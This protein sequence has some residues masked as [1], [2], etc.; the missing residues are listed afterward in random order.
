MIVYLIRHTTPNIERG[1]CYGQ[2]DIDVSDIF[3]EEANFLLGKIKSV[4]ITDVISSP[5]QRCTK[6]ATKIST[7]YT[8][9]AS[10][11]ELDFGNWE[12]KKWNA[13]PDEETNPWMNDFV[14]VP[15]PNGENYLD[16]FARAIKCYKNIQNNNTIV[17]THAGVIRSILT[18]ITNTN[19]NDSFDFKIPY[20]TIVKIDTESNEYTIL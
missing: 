2:S 11:M 9:N 7:A 12:L 15:V 14:N 20:G 3:E 18:Y 17:V 8:T 16:L 6:L 4:T 1:I 5:L 19:L 13:I 10:L